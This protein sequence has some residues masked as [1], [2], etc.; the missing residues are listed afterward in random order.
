MYTTP[1]CDD[2]LSS[3]GL[4]ASSDAVGGGAI[5]ERLELLVITGLPHLSWSCDPARPDAIIAATTLGRRL[6]D[7]AGGTGGGASAAATAELDVMRSST[8]LTPWMSRSLAA[9]RISLSSTLLAP[10]DD[11]LATPAMLPLL[12]PPPPPPPSMGRLLYE[13][14]LDMLWPPQDALLW[15]RDESESDGSS[16][17]TSG[18]LI[19]GGGGGG[20]LG[21]RHADPMC[22]DLY[23][24]SSN[25]SRG[26]GCCCCCG[27]SGGWLG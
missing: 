22:W 19:T 6:P 4:A 3:T 1:E 24:Y 7:A 17:F 18:Q 5:D 10:G 21:A 9:C 16:M 11:S 23:R 26:G 13:L 25:W 14:A 15:R 20:G 2:L 12:L 27:G 8:P